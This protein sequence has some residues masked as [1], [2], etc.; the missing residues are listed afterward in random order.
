MLKYF[1]TLT[2]QAEG[3]T[4]GAVRAQQAWQYLVAK[5]STRSLVRYQE[6]ADL[7]GY[8]DCR[9]IGVILGRIAYYCRENGLPSMT[10]IVV[11]DSGKPGI[12]YTI[13]KP[14]EFDKAREAVFRYPWYSIQPPSVDELQA[15]FERGREQDNAVQKIA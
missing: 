11:D 8:S 10:V 15:A 7:M 13:F 1:D 5:A 9:P 14:R 3:G 2:E 4:R 6:L 12:G